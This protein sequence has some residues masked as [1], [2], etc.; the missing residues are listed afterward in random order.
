MDA[1]SWIGEASLIPECNG[2]E[3]R[4]ANA[5]D[6]ATNARINEPGCAVGKLHVAQ[7]REIASIRPMQ[8]L[9]AKRGYNSVR[10]AAGAI[11]LASACV[12][13]RAEPSASEIESLLQ[14]HPE[15]LYRVIEKHPAEMIAAL[16]KA[17]QIAQTETQKNASRDAEAKTEDEFRN[18]KV[19][20][21]QHRI[22]FGNAS[23]PITIVEYSDFQCPY[24]RRERDVLVEVMKHYGD[25]VRLVVK[26]TPLEMHP[27]AM[28][29]ALMYEAVARQDPAKAFKLYDVLFDNQAKLEA[30]GEAYLGLAVRSVAGP[31]PTRVSPALACETRSQWVGWGS[32]W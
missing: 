30:Q 31:Q 1:A 5:L 25:R 16:N 27:H 19:P 2:P 18:P 13:C 10:R 20:S 28:L 17:A 9:P 4:L 6:D 8:F 29:A 14:Q 3:A 26:Q 32:V 12:G 7:C 23:A 22:A 15:I 21:L 11:A 24:C